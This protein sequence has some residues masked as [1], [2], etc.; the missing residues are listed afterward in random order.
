MSTLF[1]QIEEIVEKTGSLKNLNEGIEAVIYRH[2]TNKSDFFTTIEEA[3]NRKLNLAEYE[4]IK[5]TY[6]L[7]KEIKKEIFGSEDFKINKAHV[8]TILSFFEQ[9]INELDAKPK[10]DKTPFEIEMSKI[11]SDINNLKKKKITEAEKSIELKEL[12]GKRDGVRLKYN[13]PYKP[14]TTKTI[15]SD[16]KPTTEKENKATPSIMDALKG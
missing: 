1:E 12:E 8:G 5:Y 4:Q 15:E 2:I 6:N 16:I 14:R 11:N 10:K 7:S 13:K 3:I 9:I